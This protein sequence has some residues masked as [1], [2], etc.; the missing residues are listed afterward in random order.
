MSEQQPTKPV[1]S[2]EEEERTWAMILHLSQFAYYVVPVAGIVAPIV[3]WQIKKDEFPSLDAHG[4]VVTNWLI[5]AFVAFCICIP[6][7]FVVI[8]IPLFIALTI[9]H[10]AFAAIGAIKAYSGEV[11]PYP[12]TLIK[13]F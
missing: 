11:W 4:K 1:K 2:P 12:C 8:G 7:M 3:I 13:I 6:L 5:T 9:A 10:V